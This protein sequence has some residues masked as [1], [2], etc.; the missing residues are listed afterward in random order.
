MQFR[1]VMDFFCILTIEN[2]YKNKDKSNIKK[3]SNILYFTHNLNKL[4]IS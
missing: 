3:L 4:H 1:N 2:K